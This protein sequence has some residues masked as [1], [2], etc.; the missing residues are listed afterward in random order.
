MN[1]SHINMAFCWLL[2]IAHEIVAAAM[3]AHAII[4]LLPNLGQEKGL[5]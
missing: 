5:I 3:A 2:R 1:Y 4:L